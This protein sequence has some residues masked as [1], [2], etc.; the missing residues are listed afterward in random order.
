MSVGAVALAA[1]ATSGC[2]VGSGSGEAFGALFEVGCSK[3][4]TDGGAGALVP[5]SLKPTFF[6]GEPFEDLSMTTPT[7]MNQLRLRMQDNGLAIQYADDL[8]FDIETSYEI[9]RCLRGRTVNGV[10]DWNVT[11]T[12]PDGTV[13]WWCDWSGIQASDA[14]PF[15]AS[16][17]TPGPDG[18]A[19]LDGLSVMATYP[20]IHLTPYTDIRASL[21]T[22]STCGITNVIGIADDGWIQFEDFG[23]A[24]QADKPHDQRDPVPG[25]FVI[26]Y[27]ER[28]RADFYLTL[29]DQAIISAKEQNLPPPK[30][31]QIGGHLKGKF[32]FNLE[33]GRSAQPF[34]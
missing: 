23:S 28:M 1:A 22:L 15:D 13:T 24:E 17:I 18:G 11:E 33:R 6:A 12:L 8:V 30:E 21:A 16:A 32:D 3:L 27:G 19:S 5:Y 31:A 9:A 34:P 14:G 29:T 26:Q 20:R 2:A 25:N 4:T 10:P 7:H